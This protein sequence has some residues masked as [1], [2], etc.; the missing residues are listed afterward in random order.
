MTLRDYVAFH[1]HYDD[2]RSGLYLRLLVVQ[3]LISSVLDEAPPGPV[4]VISMCAGQGRDLIGVAR[5]HRRGRDLTGL[6]VEADPDNVAA[7]RD[8]IARAGLGG[9]SIVQG[10]A[11]RP[12][13]Y[14]GAVP[15]DLVLACGI[16]GNISHEDIEQTIGF[17]PALCAP[18]ATVLWTRHPEPAEF[19]DTIQ[20]WFA[21]AGF[22]PGPL[23]LPPGILFSV[24]SA[25][26][27]GTPPPFRAGQQLFTFVR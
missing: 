15:T 1:D 21:G 23:V 7:G 3:D 13:A 18:G 4:R 16:F 19:L 20:G 25:R 8:A 9:L 26:L 24:G 12:A 2:P 11:G 5:R 10:D 27:T 22:Q 17:L 6:L 14:S